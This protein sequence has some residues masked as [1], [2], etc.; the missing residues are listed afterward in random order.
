[1]PE[2][3]GRVCLPLLRPIIVRSVASPGALLIIAARETTRRRGARTGPGAFLRISR[4][5]DGAVVARAV[6]V[7]CTFSRVRGIIT[8]RPAGGFRDV[9]VGVVDLDACG[10]AFFNGGRLSRA[11]GGGACFVLC[12]RPASNSSADARCYLIDCSI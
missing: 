9:D 5:R 8:K 11:R 6:G 3:T 2:E 10:G 1:M 12:A 4:R 7:N